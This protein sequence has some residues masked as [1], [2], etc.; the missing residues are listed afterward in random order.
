MAAIWLADPGELAVPR[1]PSRG[2]HGHS[3]LSGR[4]SE[5]PSAAD[6]NSVALGRA[7][8]TDACARGACP[9][10]RDRRTHPYD[11]RAA[12]LRLGLPDE[13]GSYQ[14]MATGPVLL[15]AGGAG[16]R[17]AL[18]AGAHRGDN[19]VTERES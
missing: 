17:A 14:P 4:G 9:V 6:R 1:W 12:R 10:P 8:A 5:L 15:G 19:H 2:F 7:A 13:L 11:L 3:R 18:R 16:S